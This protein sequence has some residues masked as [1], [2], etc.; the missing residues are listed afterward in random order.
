[1]SRPAAPQFASEVLLTSSNWWSF[2]HAFTAEGLVYLSHQTSEFV[3][4]A[5]AS[6][7]AGG[8]GISPADGVVSPG[9][10]IISPE[11]TGNWVSRSYLDVVDYAD[12]EHPLVRRPVSL[13][14][15]LQGLSHGGSVLYTIGTHWTTNSA[16]FWREFLDAT[17]YD[18]VSAHLIDSLALSEYWPHPVLVLDRDV[19]LGQPGGAW[20]GSTNGPP[21][22]LETWRLSNAGHW[23][24]SGSVALNMPVQSLI[25]RGALLAAQSW[26]NVVTLYDA[27]DGAT[28]RQ[29]GQGRPSGCLWFDLEHS[30]GELGRG[31]WIPLGAYGVATVPAGP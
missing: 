22:T 5:D 24:R 29:V 1:M 17:A 19:F 31:L 3:A 28:L 20:V 12:A 23:T 13:P 4:W 18:G 2:S 21:S 10:V 27:T 14:G 16:W 26:D 6:A 25:N 8:G 30:D 7:P 15:T 9:A 11:P